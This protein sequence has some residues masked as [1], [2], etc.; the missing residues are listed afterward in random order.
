[1]F[2]QASRIAPV[3]IAPSSALKLAPTLITDEGK[4]SNWARSVNDCANRVT[5]EQHN[6]STFLHI[7]LPH[8]PLK[9]RYATAAYDLEIGKSR[10]TSL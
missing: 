5:H 9:L 4:L 8:S 6:S 10:T 7:D 1:M 3:T 2:L